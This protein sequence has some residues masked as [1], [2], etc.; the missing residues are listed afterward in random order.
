M[1]VVSLEHYFAFVIEGGSGSD[2]AP[3]ILHPLKA[4]STNKTKTIRD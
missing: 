1:M 2:L 3:T 4:L